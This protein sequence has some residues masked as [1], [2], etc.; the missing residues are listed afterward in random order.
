MGLKTGPRLEEGREGGKEE[1]RW[2]GPEHHLALPRVHHDS[3]PHLCMKDRARTAIAATVSSIPA[4]TN[5]SYGQTA[6][7]AGK[8]RENEVPTRGLRGKKR[9]KRVS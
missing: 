9:K 1:D 7:N 5:Q 8:K 3:C 2:T 6:T 4:A